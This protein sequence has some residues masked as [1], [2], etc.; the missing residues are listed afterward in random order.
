MIHQEIFPVIPYH[1]FDDEGR[2]SWATLWYGLA[3]GLDPRHG[4]AMPMAPPL[5]LGCV[6]INTHP[7]SRP[8][9]PP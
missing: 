2:P 9:P 1:R 6:W 4:S 7:P 5:D 8:V 3:P